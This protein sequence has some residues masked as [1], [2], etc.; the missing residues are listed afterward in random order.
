MK[1]TFGENIFAVLMAGVAALFAAILGFGGAIW[2]CSALLSGEMSQWDLILGPAAALV[3]A[4]A[5]FVIAF[6]KISTHGDPPDD[7]SA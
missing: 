4:V 6:H 5:V 2:L 3:S 7:P 1:S